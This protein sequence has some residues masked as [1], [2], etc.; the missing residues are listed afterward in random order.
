MKLEAEVEGRVVP[1]EVTGEAGRYRVTLA[2]ETL[3]VDARKVGE[4]GWSLLLGGKS[5]W[6]ALVEEDGVTVVSVD[7]EV[8]RIR[9]EEETRYLI[10]T[11]G[12][13]AA[14]SGQV[15][16]APMPG[17]VVLIEVVVGQ[18]VSRGDGLVILEAMKMENEFRAAAEGTVKEIRV[19]AGQ[20][21][22]PG[23]VLV[24]IE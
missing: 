8:H 5:Y 15:L 9:V 1:L 20:A 4:S 23:D 13:A 6:A 17:R 12:G 2:G 10:R 22:N 18:R 19:Q 14:V 21:V 3:E 24:V 16:K 11:R 7:G